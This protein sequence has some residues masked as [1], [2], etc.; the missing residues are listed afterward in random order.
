MSD[1]SPKAEPA[2]GEKPKSLRDRIDAEYRDFLALIAENRRASDAVAAMG[3]RPTSDD[4]LPTYLRELEKANAKSKAAA[5]KVEAARPAIADLM[6]GLRVRYWFPKATGGEPA[7]AIVHGIGR[8]GKLDLVVWRSPYT[9][10]SNRN[11]TPYSDGAKSG[12][13]SWMP[14][15]LL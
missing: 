12:C 3:P 2:K 10:Q 9:H 14:H 1:G 15:G 6:I 11:G 4:L 13:W 7:A 8:D 5:A